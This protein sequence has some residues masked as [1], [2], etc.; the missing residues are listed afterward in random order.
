MAVGY[1]LILG[2]GVSCANLMLE[3]FSLRQF[4]SRSDETDPPLV[5]LDLD[6]MKGA[7]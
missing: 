7:R 3:P 2:R 1:T 4:L 5:S 6:T